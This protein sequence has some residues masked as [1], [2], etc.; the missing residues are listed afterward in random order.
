[1]SEGRFPADIEEAAFRAFVRA[2]ARENAD[3]ADPLFARCADAL[4]SFGEVNGASP[5]DLAVLIRHVI[6]RASERDAAP[7]ELQVSETLGPTQADW[8][9]VG[10]APLIAGSSVLLRATPWTP[11]W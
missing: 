5:L 4:R 10:I 2:P 3:F 6:R 7:F 1:M 11:D 9:Q 8:E